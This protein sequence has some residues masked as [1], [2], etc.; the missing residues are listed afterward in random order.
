M[1]QRRKHIHYGRDGFLYGL[2][3]LLLMEWLLPLPLMTDTGSIRFFLIATFLF[4]VVS[5]LQT[6]LIVSFLARVVIILGSLYVLFPAGGTTPIEWIPLFFSDLTTSIWSILTGNWYD[7]SDVFR[8]FL[9]LILLSIMSFLLFYWTVYLRR[10]FFFLL[11]TVL[12]VTVIDTFTIYDATVAIIRVI[13]IGVLLLGFMYM[14][15]TIEANRYANIPRLLPIRM[16]LVITGLFVVTGFIS[17]ILPK[18][19]PQWDD[20]VPFLQ[21]A[22]SGEGMGQ[23]GPRRIG[24]GNNDERLGGGFIDDDTPVF[25]ATVERGVY[26]R[27][28]TKDFYT[29]A[30]WEQR[31]TAAGGYRG[32]NNFGTTEAAERTIKQANVKMYNEMRFSHMF[33][34]GEWYSQTIEEHQNDPVVLDEFTEKAEILSGGEALSPQEYT[35]EYV[36]TSYNIDGLRNVNGSDNNSEIHEYYTQL[37][38]TIPERVFELAEELTADA[39]NRYDQAKAIE[40]HFRGPEFT[41]ETEDVAVPAAGQDYVDQFLFE[42]QQGYCDNFSTS[43]IVLLRTLDIPARWVKGFTAG[44]MVDVGDEANSYTI[45]NS[46]AHSWVEVYFPGEGW[47]A[48]EPTKG[49]TNTY[50]F[51]QEFENEADPIEAPDRETSQEEEETEEVTE[52]EVE[53]EVEE[54]DQTEAAVAEDQSTPSSPVGLWVTALILL[55]LIVLFFFYRKRLITTFVLLYYRS[56]KDDR[57]FNQAYERLLWLLELNGY[58][59]ESSETLSEFATRFDQQF[60]FSDMSVLTSE[61]ERTLYS[62]KPAANTWARQRQ[63]WERIVM[64]IKP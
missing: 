39:T 27:G 50:S 8:S 9:F 30:G 7:L 19:V 22:V 10:I 59:R 62:G 23:G 54:E 31:T 45:S 32:T 36:D 53:E 21:A 20:P 12:Y 47:V 37:P 55:A 16:G 34:P 44:T 25:R 56:K 17:L 13:G 58:R 18:P 11:S 1:N 41:Y 3:F 26:W 43:M 60:G 46:D 51:D 14:Y 4:F 38:D 63:H 48:F 5:F 33:Y 6:P 42:T 52:D 29:G 15:R 49:F 35:F 40:D 2:S 57:V 28:E 61:Y 64:K 24:Y